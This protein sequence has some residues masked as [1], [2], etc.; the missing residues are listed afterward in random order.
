[1]SLKTYLQIAFWCLPKKK[2]VCVPRKKGK[3]KK[4]S[5]IF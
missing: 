3:G 4:L 1:M 5:Y 2:H